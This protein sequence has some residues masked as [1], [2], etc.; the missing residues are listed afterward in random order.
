MN[1]RP[2]TSLGLLNNSSK[3]ETF[4][5][6]ST[7]VTDRKAFNTIHENDAE[8]DEEHSLKTG[9][10]KVLRIDPNIQQEYNQDSEYTCQV[11][12]T[13]IESFT[14][15]P[16]ADDDNTDQKNISQKHSL[17]P[18]EQKNFNKQKL[19]S[20][21]PNVTEAI[22]DVVINRELIRRGRLDKSFSTPAYDNVLTESNFDIPPRRQ[23]I[24]PPVPPRK[25]VMAALASKQENLTTDPKL[26]NCMDIAS[27][28]LKTLN[29]P[30]STQHSLTVSQ[31][32]DTEQ[33][34]PN[35]KT[36]EVSELIMSN[37]IK[38]LTNKKK[39]S[40]MAKRRKIS[41]KTLG[42]NAAATIQGHLY[43]RAKDKSEV[44]Y[45]TKMY[46][47][48]MD[49]ALYGYRR[50]E[51]QKADC[52]IFLCGFTVA[53]AK[54]VHSKEFAFK[55]YHPKKTFYFAAET[56]EAMTQWIEYIRLA[57][58]KGTVNLECDAKDL[59]SETEWCSDD[60]LDTS[61]QKHLNTSSPAT[62]HSMNSTVSGN[63][64]TPPLQ[65]SH[66]F[67]SLKKTFGRY[68]TSSNE[69]QDNR[70]LGIFSTNKSTEKK[71]TDIVPT[72]QFKTYRKVVNN[73]GLQLGATSMIH[74]N[75]SDSYSPSYY[76]IN[77]N[78]LFLNL[79]NS[80][81]MTQQQEES[82]E[83]KACVLEITNDKEPTQSLRK[84]H[85]FLHASNPNLLDFNFQHAVDFP[86]LNT[87]NCNWDHSNQQTGMT[88]LDLMLQ[89]RAEEMK[90]MYD[91][92]VDQGMERIDEKNMQKNIE[93]QVIKPNED[94]HVDK[95]LL[96]I[97]KRCLPTPPDYAQSFKPND[98]AILYT[99]SKEGLKLRDFGYELIS[100]DDDV[101][102]KEQSH[103]Q[104][105]KI[106]D[107]RMSIPKRK[108]V[109]LSGSIKKKSGFTWMISHEKDD[110]QQS[111]SQSCSGSFRK[112]K[113]VGSTAITD[114]S[115]L[116]KAKKHTFNSQHELQTISKVLRKNSAPTQGGNPVNI[117]YFSKLP[118]SSVNEKK[119]LGS[120]KLHRAI[121]GRNN[122]TNSASSTDH[123]IFSSITFPKV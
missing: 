26:K 74:T 8:T 31:N 18:S 22:N 98:Q 115:K 54:E 55:V 14:P 24:I 96:E 37:K 21:S 59:Y 86:A 28:G 71:S 30:S 97:Q 33:E 47:I 72:A 84:T 15:I 75:I 44:A 87:S 46:F 76:G 119:L 49:I 79:S 121:F 56:S 38:T 40:L 77:S 27:N 1:T 81:N 91:K 20:N 88:L 13:I 17:A 63:E 114:E 60:D 39:N 104:D 65:K 51:S 7:I 85:N 69:L 113:F 102:R 92:R 11:Q 45:W 62:S 68:S 25:Q 35:N 110:N 73:G 61:F 122:N 16:Y 82:I 83:S 78:S 12:E 93:K 89:Q 108:V 48:L 99:R 34:T 4:K 36:R 29:L 58:L 23:N 118:F 57:T 53:P 67:G 111:S 50:K 117:P 42:S 107:G 80:S 64:Q 123:E 106:N 109:P 66:Y 9:V 103:Q 101:V 10:S 41:L 70:F 112:G 120:P 6:S 90:D 19:Q 100:N 5:K 116:L 52:A 2:S 3:I 105:V 94:V 32:V 95:K 43:R